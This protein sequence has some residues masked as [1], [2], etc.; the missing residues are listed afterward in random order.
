MSLSVSTLPLNKRIW[1][2][3]WP[4]MVSNAAVPLVAL[5]D[6]AVLGHL[7]DPKALGAAAIAN[8]LF[9]LI[10]ALFSFLRMSTTSQIAQAFGSGH[11]SLVRWLGLRNL[12]LGVV[13]SVAGALSLPLWSAFI[14]EYLSDDAALIPL[15]QAYFDIRGYALPAVAIQYWLVGMLIGIQRPKTSLLILMGA[16]ILNAALDILLVYGFKGGAEAVAWASTVAEY[17]VALCAWCWWKKETLHWPTDISTTAQ[18]TLQNIYALGKGVHFN[19]FIRTLLLLIVMTSFT[20]FGA[21]LDTDILSANAIFMS[22]LLLISHVLDAFAHAAEALV[23][24]RM[25]H[26]SK[27]GALRPVLMQTALWSAAAATCIFAFLVV[28]D[29]IIF[30]LLTDKTA[31]QDSLETYQVWLWCLPLAAWMSYWVDGVMVGAGQAQAMRNGMIFSCL[32][33]YGM[34]LILP[35]NNPNLWMSFYAF[36]LIRFLTL[37]PQIHQLARRGQPSA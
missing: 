11:S 13:L 12:K 6:T 19:L 1:H 8:A 25:T 33:F 17:T 36:L 5:V 28:F 20:A 18:Q 30:Q 31:I 22:L 2:L 21:R 9:M 29:E 15:S 16:N 26:D 27:R 10:A 4:V 24:E 7:E 35:S 23:G 32:V 34:Y 37:W 3:S 14:I